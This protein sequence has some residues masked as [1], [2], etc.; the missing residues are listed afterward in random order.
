[1]MRRV[2]ITGL[3]VLS[4]VGNTVDEYW[5]SLIQGKSG[6]GRVTR[7]DVSDFKT[8]IAGELK[9]FNPDLYVDAKEQRRIDL[10]S[11]YGISASV[12]A[13]ESSGIDFSSIDPF[14]AGV[15][16]GS[17]IGGLN[18]LE[19]QAETYFTKGHS[20]ISPFYI[21]G[22]IT[23]IVAGHIAIRYG[24]RGPNFATVSACASGAH[25]IGSAFH[26]IQRGDA[27]VMV[28]GGSEGAITPTALAGFINIHALSRR[29][30]EPERA[31][32]PFNIDRDGFVMGEG[33]GVFILE[34]LEHARKRGATIFA[35]MSGVG[36]TGDGHHITAPHPDGIGAAKAMELA[37]ANSS[38]T[39]GDVDYVNCHGTSTPDGD[40]SEVN[41]IKL[42]FGE[43]AYDLTI[44]STKSMTGHL[45]GAAGAIE[46]AATILAAKNDIIPPTINYD[47]PDPACDLNCTPNTAVQKKV[48]FAISNSFGFGGHNACLAVKKYTE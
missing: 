32:R 26:A 34:E 6:I 4:P 7:F 31:S 28:A 5:N 19:R 13:V 17:G 18:V 42:L 21:T 47:N 44:S 48:A 24:L 39:V 29:N 25:A 2:V 14:R 15:I 9:D 12:Q 1:M 46:F 30:D 8:Q 37:I 41:A 10:F 43:K 11:L 35:E 22:M 36:F 3:G 23:D 40:I 38:K 45:L 27:D 16:I 20:R 33:A